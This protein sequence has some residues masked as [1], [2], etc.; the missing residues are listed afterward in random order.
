MDEQNQ[1]VRRADL[2][3]ELGIGVRTLVRWA[4]Q[5]YGPRPIKIG[6][7]VVRYSRA[8]VDEFLAK[9]ASEATS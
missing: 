4:A 1:W 6:P 7:R 5:E 8:Q 2:A 9:R 3:L